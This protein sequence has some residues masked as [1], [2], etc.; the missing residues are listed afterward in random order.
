MNVFLCSQLESNVLGLLNAAVLAVYTGTCIL[1]HVYISIK[2]CILVHVYI[3][4]IIRFIS[5]KTSIYV[6]IKYN[7]NKKSTIHILQSKQ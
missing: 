1:V 5:D 4:I 2:L 6:Y 3:S 7:K